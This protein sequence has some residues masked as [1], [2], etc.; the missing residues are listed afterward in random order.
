MVNYNDGFC[1]L[2]VAPRRLTRVFKFSVG[3][4][5]VGSAGWF[6]FVLVW[7]WCFRCSVLCLWVVFDTV[8]VL[9]ACRYGLCI[10]VCFK[11]VDCCY[12]KVLCCDYI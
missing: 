2:R 5:C 3:F 11:V 9:S 7:F 4:A 8:F 6:C 10:V 1:E 12:F